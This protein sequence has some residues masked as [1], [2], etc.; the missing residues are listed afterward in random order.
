LHIIVLTTTNL[1][2]ANF[3]T[4]IMVVIIPLTTDILMTLRHAKW[5]NS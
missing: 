1:A 4:K 5:L 2:W 3:V